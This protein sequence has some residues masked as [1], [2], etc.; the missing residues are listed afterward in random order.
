MKKLLLKTLES[1]SLK[2]SNKFIGIDE[3]KLRRVDVLDQLNQEAY[4]ILQR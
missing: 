2:K 4:S 3:F 1:N